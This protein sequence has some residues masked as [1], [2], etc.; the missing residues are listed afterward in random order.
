M[1]ASGPNETS[2]MCWMEDFFTGAWGLSW[3]DSVGHQIW[4]VA[5]RLEAVPTPVG[6]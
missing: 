1:L 5:N 3:L 2:A 4:A 6:P